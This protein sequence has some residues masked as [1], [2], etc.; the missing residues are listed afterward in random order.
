[1]LKLSELEN[2]L[3]SILVTLISGQCSLSPIW[4]YEEITHTHPKLA[5]NSKLNGL[6]ETSL[7]SLLQRSVDK[8]A[9]KPLIPS[10]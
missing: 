2:I 1:M 8:V 6:G 10:I 9:F 7:G 5:K 3:Y 4:Q